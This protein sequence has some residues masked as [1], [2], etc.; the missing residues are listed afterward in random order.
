MRLL[1]SICVVTLCVTVTPAM[2][3]FDFGLGS[4][5]STYNSGA[6][7]LT[8]TP[9]PQPIPTLAVVTR[10]DIPPV[11]Q[12]KLYGPGVGGL[13]GDFL[14]QMSITSIHTNS[15]PAKDSADGSGTFALTDIAGGVLQGNTLGK[16][17][18]VGPANI[19]A[20][21]LSQVTWTG[22]AAFIGNSGS[23]SMSFPGLPQP[24]IGIMMEL[25]TTDHWFGAGD[26]TTP[27]GSVDAS[28]V[29]V[30][31]AVLLGFLGLG[32]AGLKLR[33]YA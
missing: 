4:V 24:W 19:F 26:Y 14:L 5:N 22:G 20:G 23:V 16:W 2:A 27:S 11:G 28:V 21:T 1:L 6:G 33:K 29:P 13:G 31:A 15:D 7:V 3:M 10:L 18:R 17:S 30:P 12:A 9:L 25:S 8:V 32:T